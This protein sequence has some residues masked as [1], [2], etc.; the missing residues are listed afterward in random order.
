MPSLQLIWTSKP[1][2]KPAPHRVAVLLCPQHSLA[3]LGLVLDVFRMANHLPGAPY[4]ELLRISETGQ[5]VAHED[6]LLRVNG[7][8]AE[9]IY[10]KI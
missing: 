10:S 6:G 5:P 3:S 9:I 1:M 4:F 2:P 7:D 8:T